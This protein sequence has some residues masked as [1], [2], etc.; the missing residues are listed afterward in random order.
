MDCFVE[1]LW[2]EDVR[3][4]ELHELWA[5]CHELE[6]QVCMNQRLTKTFVVLSIIELLI[7]RPGERLKVYVLG[8]SLWVGWEMLLLGLAA[9]SFVSAAGDGD[10]TWKPLICDRYG[11]IACFGAKVNCMTSYIDHLGFCMIDTRTGKTW[12]FLNMA[13][14]R[15]NQ[16]HGAPIALKHRFIFKW[17]V[18]GQGYWS[19]RNAGAS[20]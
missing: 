14:C 20:L 3:L 19:D 6:R 16:I 18:H 4:D 5:R 15:E 7:L 1:L 12:M 8:L 17:L 13:I 10:F 2:F 9:V 11:W